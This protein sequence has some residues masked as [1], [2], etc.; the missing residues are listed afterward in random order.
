[1]GSSQSSTSSST[2]SS[3]A[4]TPSSSSAIPTKTTTIQESPPTS[5]PTT[6]ISNSSDN[7]NKSNKQPKLTGIDLVNYKCRKKKFLYDKCKS[8][9]YSGDFLTGKNLY[10]EEKCGDIFE[11][12]RQ[13]YLKNLKREFFDKKNKKPKEGS[14]LA[15]ELG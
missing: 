7:N 6:S 10:Q 2:S 8:E 11:T 9:F 13:C 5:D 4:T 12:Y 1:M 14:I 3:G 15:E